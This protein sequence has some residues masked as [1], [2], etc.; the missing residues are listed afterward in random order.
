MKES[1]PGVYISTGQIIKNP[2]S[3]F[4]NILAGKYALKVKNLYYEL[5]NGDLFMQLETTAI[6]GVGG[7]WKKCI[8]IVHK[9][10]LK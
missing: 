9:S 2:K 8:T 3:A 6:N 10:L 1:S 5:A 4:N 7:K